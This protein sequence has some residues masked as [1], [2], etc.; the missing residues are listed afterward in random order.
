M[1]FDI[2]PV[3]LDAVATQVTLDIGGTPVIYAHGPERATQI[4]WPGQAA[5][6]S[7]RLVFDP[8]PSTGTKVFQ[9]SGAWALFRL[10]EQGTLKRSE[11]ADRYKLTFA[12]GDRRASYEIRA[13]SVINPFE[14]GLLADFSAQSSDQ[15]RT[16]RYCGCS[17]RLSRQDPA[18]GDFVKQTAAC[19][20][21]SL[22]G[23]M[24][25]MVAAS[26]AVLGEAWLPAWLEVAV[27]RFA[28]SPDVCGPGAVI[29]LW[30]PSV[31]RVG[32][33]FPLTLAAVAGDADPCGLLR[34]GGGFLAAAEHAGREALENDL[35]PDALAA[36]LAAA[37]RIPPTDAGADPLLCPADGALWWTEG[38][39]LVSA[40]VFA[41][42]GLP[43]EN[44]FVGMLVSC[45]C[46]QPAF[47]PEQPR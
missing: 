31:D 32:R 23:W 26:R 1:R 42:R 46:G 44:T 39:P 41:T 18:R 25:R 9:A 17:N 5:T 12:T 30:M 35:P 13:G 40:G 19:L 21:R 37:M 4:S 47:F 22:D 2:T 29:G 45:F 36:R 38:A 11:W 15:H 24:Q 14:P 7:V 8:P 27:W 20:H 28:L 3:D 6:S 16:G 10:F 43:D 33:Y 34:E